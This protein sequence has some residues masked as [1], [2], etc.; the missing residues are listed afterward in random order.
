MEF[1]AQLT[2]QVICVDGLAERLTISSLPVLCA[3]IDSVLSQSSENEG[4]IYCL[5]GQFNV[6]RERI[7]N[8]VRFTLLNC[9][10]ALAW[11]VTYHA[12]TQEVVI[13]CTIDKREEEEEFVESIQ[14]FMA[15]WAEGLEASL[16]GEMQ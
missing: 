1:F 5:W 12:S 13:H 8:G 9:P 11:T 14:Q 6:A 16:L 4:E 10:H 3:S 2:N 7:R 15:D